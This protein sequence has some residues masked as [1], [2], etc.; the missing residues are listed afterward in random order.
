MEA[1]VGDDIAAGPSRLG[2]YEHQTASHTAK[3]T[4]YMCPLIHDIFTEAPRFSYTTFGFNASNCNVYHTDA[5]EYA[6]TL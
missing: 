1:E 3:V 4:S 6:L 2:Y 5:D